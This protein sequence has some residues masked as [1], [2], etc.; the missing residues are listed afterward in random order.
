MLR[1]LTRNAI[2]KYNDDP[3][4]YEQFFLDNYKLE[5]GVYIKLKVDEE[6]QKLIIDDILEVENYNDEIANKELE[7]EFKKLDKNS[8]INVGNKVIDQKGKPRK[9]IY[10]TNCLSFIIKRQNII[11]INKTYFIERYF[12]EL[13]QYNKFIQL[14]NIFKNN[15]ELIKENKELYELNEYLKS[16]ER[17]RLFERL[18][19]YYNNS[20]ENL[21]KYILTN[22]LDKKYDEKYFKM[23]IVGFDKYYELE[24]KLYLYS[25]GFLKNEF[26][27][28]NDKN[29][30]IGISSFDSAENQKKVFSYSKTRNN[31]NVVGLVPYYNLKIYKDVY[32][33]LNYK[34]KNKKNFMNADFNFDIDA[35]YFKKEGFTYEFYTFGNSITDFEIVGLKELK[36]GFRYYNYLQLPKDNI[37]TKDLNLWQM[38]DLFFDIYLFNGID[39]KVVLKNIDEIKKLNISN[40]T[41]NTF[42]NNKDLFH[43]FFNRGDDSQIKKNIFKI[44]LNFIKGLAISNIENNKS[45][46]YKVGQGINMHISLLNYFDNE[47][48]R[49]YVNNFEKIT[50]K[51]NNLDWD[52]EIETLEEFCYVAGILGYYLSSQTKAEKQTF[53]L[54]DSIY[55]ASNIEMIKYRITMLFKK[56]DHEI[57]IHNK[58]FRILFNSLIKYKTDKKLSMEEKV[59]LYAGSVTNNILYM[60]KEGNDKNE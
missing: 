38:K 25:Y 24:S 11:E 21:E 40:Y 29:K 31:S 5:L 6:N 14:L 47:K 42:F 13:E 30:L 4:G 49:I 50:E 57:S 2:K 26:N 12:N 16:D 35:N 3:I 18:R 52:Y 8:F 27:K 46:R 34:S 51:F 28:L 33:Y 32:N 15:K 55:N 22:Y 44:T 37:E 36:K 56:Y 48:G 19:E 23:F 39:S 9:K 59:Y 58:R 17:K 41:K 54:L 60:K 7:L 20:Y 53:Q 1:D 45:F 10:S 43:S